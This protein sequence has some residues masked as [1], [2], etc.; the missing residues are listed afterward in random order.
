MIVYDTTNILHTQSPKNKAH[1][2]II[3]KSFIDV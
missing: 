2:K 3:E 1:K